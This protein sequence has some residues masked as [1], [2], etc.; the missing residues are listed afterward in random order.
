MNKN[1]YISFLLENMSFHTYL[2]KIISGDWGDDVEIGN[3]AD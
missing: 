3:V 2:Q 1:E